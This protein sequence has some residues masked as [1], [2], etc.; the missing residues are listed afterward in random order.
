MN[1]LGDVHL[2]VD[3]YQEPLKE[4]LLQTY[5]YARHVSDLFYIEVTLKS[6]TNYVTDVKSAFPSISYTDISGREQIFA[7]KA[8][9][10]VRKSWIKD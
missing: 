4:L 3:S 7:I 8:Y 5:A 6:Y 10:L 2:I 9:S 1:K